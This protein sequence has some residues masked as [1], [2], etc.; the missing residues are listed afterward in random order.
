MIVL[1]HI[2]LTVVS[3]GVYR[4]FNTKWIESLAFLDT[5]EHIKYNI[6]FMM[7]FKNEYITVRFF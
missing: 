6:I 4:Y 1:R 7:T 5:N 2:F 3:N